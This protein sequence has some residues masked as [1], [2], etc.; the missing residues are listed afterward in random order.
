M[1][2]DPE[3]RDLILGAAAEVYAERS[4]AAAGKREV[5]KAAGVPVRAVSE[6]GEHRIDLLR[7]VIEQLPFPPVAEHIAAQAAHPSEPALQA[8]MRHPLHMEAKSRQDRWL[9]GYRVVIAQVIR[10]YGDGR[11]G[12]RLPRG[13]AP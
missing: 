2:V 5:A 6:V 11:L 4:I 8:L 9:A 10:M 7:Q 12:D 3:K 1:A 13:M